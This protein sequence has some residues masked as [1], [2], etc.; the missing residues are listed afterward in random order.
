MQRKHKNK[1]YENYIDTLNTKNI[2][3]TNNI[4]T[5]ND[6]LNINVL[7]ESQ[8]ND[9]KTD[10]EN[11]MIIFDTM[12]YLEKIMNSYNNNFNSI[13][14]QFQSDHNRSEMYLNN[15]KISD[16]NDFTRQLL[17]FSRFKINLCN[18]SFPF[19][20]IIQM[21]CT[22]ASFVFSFVLMNKL[23]T[24]YRTGKHVTSNKSKYFVTI[25]NPET[26]DIKLDAIYYIKD[27]NKNIIVAKV[28]VITNIC[29][30]YKKKQYEFCKWGIINWDWL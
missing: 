23:Y 9:I 13:T 1:I 18:T 28:N 27:V 15:I 26:L 21:L 24:N 29:A 6:F 22:Q 10:I 11:K 8:I 25:K 16:P 17:T 14:Q 2:I 4:V 7:N 19:D 5:G 30:I 3:T 12:E 20:I